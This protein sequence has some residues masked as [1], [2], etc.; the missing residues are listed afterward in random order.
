MPLARRPA[1]DIKLRF[2]EDRNEMSLFQ[3]LFSST[4]SN[5]KSSLFDTK[6]AFFSSAVP[7]V[8]SIDDII[9]KKKSI[10]KKRE[11]L[12]AA[13][14]DTRPEKKRKSRKEGSEVAIGSEE[15]KAV[16]EEKTKKE[17]KG[18]KPSMQEQ[19]SKVAKAIEKTKRLDVVKSEQ[20]EE[21]DVEEDVSVAPEASEEG[22]EEGE[23]DA[24]S[25]TDS[26]KPPPSAAE[27]A[28]K[29]KRTIF[30]GNVKVTKTTRVKLKHFF[31]ANGS[32]VESV[33][34]RSLAFQAEAKGDR[35]A[36]ALQ[37]KVDEARAVAH[38]YV[39]FEDAESVGPALSLNNSLFQ[40]LH[41]R[42]DRASAPSK[43]VSAAKKSSSSSSSDP[44][45]PSLMSG[46]QHYDPSRSLFVG[47]LP[48][49]CKDEELI[50]LFSDKAV[51][52]ELERSV[53]AVRVVR[54]PATQI[55]KGFA[56]VLFRSKAS[57]RVAL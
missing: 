32:T 27:Q 48:F 49:H 37:G 16:K 7:L 12:V 21:E 56:F 19:I 8:D 20:M 13:D 9:P 24:K 36:K 4:G 45:D 46:P 41:L 10:K 42:V 51:A 2:K 54:D 57:L 35:R 28:E 1:G 30:V 53:E 11:A 33:R 14:E 52:P 31:S 6:S 15:I 55:G 29:L 39:V 5:Y 23:E 38:A 50:A 18:S 25:L 3:G 26:K 22:E 17:K 43:K 47:N 44:A 34:L 40:G